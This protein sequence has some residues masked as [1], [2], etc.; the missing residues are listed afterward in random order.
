MED[1]KTLRDTGLI[2][3][4]TQSSSGKTL[5]NAMVLCALRQR[6]IAVQS[7]KTG[8]DYIDTAYSSRYAGRPSYNLDFW[9]MES[10]SIERLAREKTKEV[11]GVVEGVMGLFDGIAPESDDGSTYTLAKLLKWP[12][13]LVVPAAKQGRS[14]RATIRGFLEEAGEGVVQGI[15]FN[16][17]SGIS[18]GEYLK[19]TVADMGVPVV[20]AIPLMS[21]IEWPERHLGLQASQEWV[22]TGAER[23]A[24]EAERYLDLDQMLGIAAKV[25]FPDTSSV[26]SKPIN[27]WAKGKRIAMARDAAFHFY[28]QGNLDAL[29]DWGFEWVEFSPLEDS[30]LPPGVDGIILGGGFPEVYAEALSRN[31]SMNASIRRAIESGM[32]CYAEC[33]GFMYLS[34]AIVQRDG[35]ESPMLG[36]VPGKI[37][38]TERL[39][40]FGYSECF[41]NVND[42][43]FRAHEFHYSYWDAES[44]RANLW[45]VK[46]R[47]RSSS[48][49]EGYGT[50]NLHA[51]YL[52]LYFP[53]AEALFKKLFGKATH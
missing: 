41:L 51:S 22:P 52:H 5:V 13:F 42:T 14:I 30:K 23:L 6:G 39:Q 19:R 17:V 11:L 16:K 8:P 28:Y 47:S 9:L 34:E 50:P 26:D 27:H 40:N 35:Q 44:S 46:K 7:F 4:G 15:I 29:R 24:T 20:G 38:M 49:T 21:D 18:H 48:R 53:G 1:L 31:V 45:T 12:V 10:G 32:P 36:I 25:V 2:I 37:H 43:G 33:G 3:A